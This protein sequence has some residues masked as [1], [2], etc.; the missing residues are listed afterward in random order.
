MD[1]EMDHRGWRHSLPLLSPQAD[2][3]G[4]S[5]WVLTFTAQHS[6]VPH[7]AALLQNAGDGLRALRAEKAFI[8]QEGDG[9]SQ[10]QTVTKPLAIDWNARIWALIMSEGW[11]ERGGR[12]GN[13][14]HD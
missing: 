8:T 3:R 14:G 4:P 6:A 12:G 10:L 7:H 13:P 2:S 9:A 5:P 1:A 11:G